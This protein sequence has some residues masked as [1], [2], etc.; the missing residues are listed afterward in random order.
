VNAREPSWRRRLGRLTLKLG[1][2]WIALELLAAALVAWGL[3]RLA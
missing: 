2:A 3:L 1:G